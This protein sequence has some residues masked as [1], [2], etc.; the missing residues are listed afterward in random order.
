M[1][2]WQ[3]A[4][5]RKGRGFP[6]LAPDTFEEKQ[7]GQLSFKRITLTA[8]LLMI[9]QGAG[10]VGGRLAALRIWTRDDKD[11]GQDAGSRWCARKRNQGKDKVL[12][13]VAIFFLFSFFFSFFPFSIFAAHPQHM[14]VFRLGVK[15]AAAASLRDSHS[16]AGSELHLQTTLQF[17][18]IL[19][20]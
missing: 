14:E 9:Q 8:I 10:M 15:L 6:G 1:R 19:G 7:Q 18:A 16:N 12:A 3:G 13:Q 11:S 5:Q 2:P 17:R 20:P 4:W